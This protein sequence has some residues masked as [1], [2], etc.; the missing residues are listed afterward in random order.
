MKGRNR[1]CI[2]SVILL[3]LLCIS[4]KFRLGI[5]NSN[6]EEP[7]TETSFDDLTFP[8]TDNEG[9][10]V[11]TQDTDT[12]IVY[13]SSSSGNDD[14]S[15]LD[16]D[17][18][19]QTINH[20]ISLLR[21]GYPDHLLLRRGDEWEES[22]QGWAL[23]GRSGSDPLVVSCYGEDSEPRPL[24]RG[25]SSIQ[26]DG[27]E[28]IRHV[29]F[30]G[31]EMYCSAGDES[32]AD[33][34]ESAD[35]PSGFGLTGGGSDILIE[36]CRFSFF[37][38]GLVIQSYGDGLVSDIKVRRCVITDMYSTDS[39]SQG[40]YTYEINGLLVEECIFDHNGW[41]I[42]GD[43][44]TQDGGMATM[45]NHNAYINETNQ[46]V[47]R[48]NLFLRGSSIGVKMCSED[49][50]DS[51][52]AVFDDNL[53][54]D[55]EIGISIGGNGESEYRFVNAD[56]VNNV[57]LNIGVGNHTGRSFSWG[58]DIKDNCN[59]LVAANCF[60]NQPWFGNSYA[61]NM[62]GISNAEIMVHGNL[63]YNI[64]NFAFIMEPTEDWDHISISGNI[65]DSAGNDFN[66]IYHNG[67]FRDFSYN[68]NTYITPN[69]TP[70]RIAEEYTD[71]AGWELESGED[72]VSYEGIPYADPGRTLESYSTIVGADG[73][74]GG[75][76][77][78]AR[79]LSH[80]NWNEQYT[81]RA[82]NNYLRAGFD[83]TTVDLQ[84]NYGR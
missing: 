27:S 12:R 64:N 13:V 43:G 81:A 53:F 58:L 52:Q 56:I 38:G 35:R 71:L 49:P 62:S 18:P 74:A 50:N 4:C 7:A 19:V 77:L 22:I 79:Q 55:G 2:P 1:L 11:V 63:A 33:Y 17:H 32:S 10:T 59:T 73:T 41:K 40:M 15:G 30:I 48:G 20:G 16:T 76:I 84:Y 36:N 3:L 44:G 70:F 28:D 68:A 65:I 69:E 54:Y 61:V 60:L 34:D 23:S 25:N 6:F 47:I 66:C 72:N 14:N 78:L 24:L 9:W 26:I 45:F 75:F 37:R 57:F 31:L 51:I 46:I 29:W 83:R 5:E 80:A 42:P 82:V 39:H 8:A 67:N 21:D